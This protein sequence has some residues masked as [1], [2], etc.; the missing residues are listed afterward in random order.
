MTRVS[1]HFKGNNTEN[2]VD[3]AH[4]PLRAK[5]KNEIR[6]IL[7]TQEELTFYYDLCHLIQ[8]APLSAFQCTE[9][10]ESREK[11]AII[12]PMALRIRRNQFAMQFTLRDSMTSM[13]CFILIARPMRRLIQSISLHSN[14]TLWC[15]Y[16]K[17]LYRRRSSRRT[18]WK[19]IKGKK[20]HE[21]WP[22]QSEQ[23]RSTVCK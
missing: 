2:D 6:L 1:I 12:L 17:C 16:F 8:F 21:P 14:H 22:C 10:R 20:I 9:H 23:R 11:N 19:K 15:G 5:R 3:G 7:T 4:P 18:Y 13:R